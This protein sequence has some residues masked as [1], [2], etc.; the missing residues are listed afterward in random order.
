MK[1]KLKEEIDKIDFFELAKQEKNP[2]KRIRLLA[3][4]QVKRKKV[5]YEIAEM[6]QIT[7]ETIRK[8]VSGF[9]QH[10]LEALEEKPRKGRKRKLSSE[11]EEEF[12]V[13]VERLQE[14]REGGRIRASDIQQML[15][16]KFAVKLAQPSIY[17]LLKRCRLS[18]ISARSKHPK[19]NKVE[20]EEF[21]KNSKRK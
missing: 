13:E 21:K 17:H 16:E 8:W 5:R 20:Q 1:Q 15:E 11:R 10:G 12:R 19:A 18:W 2:R 7:T 14:Q 3:M 9:L 6:Y 4:G